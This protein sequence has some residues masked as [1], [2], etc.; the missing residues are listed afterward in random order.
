MVHLGI[1]TSDTGLAADHLSRMFVK[2]DLEK[3]DINSYTC[4][5]FLRANSCSP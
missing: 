4:G 1:C 3:G 2:L 5:L